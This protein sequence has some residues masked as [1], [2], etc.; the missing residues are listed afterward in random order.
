M[1][2]VQVQVTNEQL[3][4]L[5]RQAEANGEAV[6]AQLRKAVDAWVANEAHR[7]AVERALGSIGGFHSGLGDLSERHDEYLAEDAG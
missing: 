6:S 4:A 2:R 1:P 3:E 5:R 7:L